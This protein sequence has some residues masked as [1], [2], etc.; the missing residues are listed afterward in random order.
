MRTTDETIAEIL[1]QVAG[2]GNT[3]S[4]KMMG[5]YVLYCNEKVVALVCANELVVKD[6]KQGRAFAPDL[7][8]MPAYPGAKPGLHVPADRRA[9][10]DWL[11]KLIKITAD[12]L[13]AK[14]N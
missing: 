2:A 12:A 6:T 5:E 4:I 3:R 13:P 11:A 9:D 14:K 10:T 7:E 1:D 8:L